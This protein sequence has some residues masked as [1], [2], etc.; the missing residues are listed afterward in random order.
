MSQDT[1]KFRQNTKDQFYTKSSIATK[2]VTTILTR[3]PETTTYQ[4]TEPSAG[5]G[6]FLKA[7]PSTIYCSG[8]DIEPKAVEIEQADF[9]KWTPPAT[10]QPRIF[11]GNPPFGRQ[12]SAAKSFIKHAS[13]YASIIAFILPKS[14]VKPSMNRVF[15]PYFHCIHSED[16]PKDSFE[17]NG[18]AYDV[19]C[20]F[21]IWKKQATERVLEQSIEPAGFQYVKHTESFHIA[22]RRV[23]VNAGRAHPG[24][25]TYAFQSHYFLRLQEQHIPR[26]TTIIDQV[27]QH[28]FPSNTTGPRS[29]SK[30]E[31]NEV[32]NPILFELNK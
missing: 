30:S 31:I 24:G 15:P 21:Q 3:C 27:N 23:G 13:A 1:G 12:G 18:H 14:F 28:T 32:L 10:N 9:L 16:L 7:V 2:C 29:L 5:N 11:F 6:A 26:I 22:V 4:W 20:V 25:A 8:L 17:V 19:P